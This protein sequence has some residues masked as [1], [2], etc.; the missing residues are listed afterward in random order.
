MYSESTLLEATL[1]E[2]KPNTVYT[3]S[4]ISFNLNGM[5]DTSNEIKAKTYSASPTEAPMNVSVEA[6]SSTVI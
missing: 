4:V 1:T 2:L 6:S 3:I 5:G